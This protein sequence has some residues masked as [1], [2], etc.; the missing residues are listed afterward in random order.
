MKPFLF[1]AMALT[2]AMAVAAPAAQA[3]TIDQLTGNAVAAYSLCQ[4]N[5]YKMEPRVFDSDGLTLERVS[6]TQLTV[7][8]LF[9]AL[10]VPRSS[11]GSV[12]AHTEYSGDPAGLFDFRARLTDADGNET[13]DGTQLRIVKGEAATNGATYNNLIGWSLVPIK[14]TSTRTD[15][16]TWKVIAD[17][18]DVIFDIT[19][20]AD[21]TLHLQSSTCIGLKAHNK[22]T[23]DLARSFNIITLD[24]YEANATASDTYYEYTFK[25]NPE[26]GIIE[27]FPVVKTLQRTYPVRLEMN[28]SDHTFTILNLGNNGY[29]IDAQSRL[30]PIHGIYDPSTRTLTFAQSQFAKPVLALESEATPSWVDFQIER[31]DTVAAKNGQMTDVFL[32]TYTQSDD[33]RHVNYATGWVTNG[34]TTRTRT[35]CDLTLDDYT[36]YHDALL[37]ENVNFRGGYTHTTIQGG[38]DMTADIDVDLQTAGTKDGKLH[39][40]GT[41]GL[42]ANVDLVDHVE[43]YI[44]PG[45][46]ADG[47]VLAEP[48]GHENGHAQ[49]VKIADYADLVREPVS[50]GMF[51]VPQGR[52]TFDANYS[53]DTTQP[54]LAYSIFAKAVYTDASQLAPT[55]HDLTAVNWSNTTGI[56]DLDADTAP[57]VTG[58]YDLQGRPAAADARG[59]LV[60]R[61]SDGTSRMLRR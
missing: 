38:N 51:R 48:F 6:D 54:T 40:H 52:L 30:S 43:L 56:T 39:M 50:S 9:N 41:V 49:A 61:L 1:P 27:C 22:T 32:G 45:N 23:P 14:N 5:S 37:Y 28:A 2:L 36:Y 19:T 20:N 21:G 33:L 34:G 16:W 57:V 8:G 31:F 55:F 13:A 47:A 15:R 46:Y 18:A 59:I 53:Y 29:G 26:L 10:V 44:C 60:Q 25:G 3:F 11:D 12:A 42:L 35:T 58:V 4:S 24:T 7:K 17:Q